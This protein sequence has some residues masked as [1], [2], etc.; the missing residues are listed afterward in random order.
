MQ[1]Q[2]HFYFTNDLHSHFEN[3][4]YVATAIKNARRAHETND[5]EFYLFDIGDH[6]DRM[7]IIGEAFLGKAN[8]ELMNQLAYDVVTIGNNEGL[9]L[10]H[11]DLFHLYDQAN[12]QVVCSN[13]KSMTEHQPTWLK[14]IIKL[15]SRRGIP[16]S[17]L[18]LTA[19]FNDYYHLLHWHVADVFKTLK[20]M[21]SKVD[22][23]KSIVVLLSHLG[24]KED[25]KIAEK[26]PEIDVIIG[27]HTHHLLPKGKTVHR[28]LITSAGKS[29]RS[30]G[31][32]KLTYCKQKQ[33][34][35]DKQ[36]EI[37]DVTKKKSDQKTEKS[38]DAYEAQ[39]KA[40]LS[41]TV[42]ETKDPLPMDWFQ[43]TKVMKSLTK[44]LKGWTGSDG[45]FLNA[46][47]LL[48]DFSQGKITRKDI[49]EACP[50]PINPCV[51]PLTGE[52]LL[53]II[54]R[55]ETKDVQQYPFVGF[56]FRGKVVGK[57]VY[58]GITF[59]QEIKS[60]KELQAEDIFI[61]GDP[62]K[63]STIYQIATADMFTFG[64]LFPE[65]SKSENIQLFLPEFMRDLL[66]TSLLALSKQR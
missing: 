49:H 37:I 44:T 16:I 19:P 35:V 53:N 42:A 33:I 26:F 27:G 31:K 57:M 36:A 50:H 4:P 5:E 6:L 8:V 30:V 41:Q 64:H 66:A 48:K 25:E 47:L 32:V 52:E 17:V 62:L 38:I 60:K 1:E 11:E 7:H 61:Q 24:L 13:L 65:I 40:I 18:G 12:F 9:T 59:K 22:Y 63:K 45:A 58:S 20:Q 54:R 10:A 29:C 51:V 28:T 56:G 15:Q 2:I 14:P 43:E 34:I 21:L 55:A 39:A 46:G 3:W 23:T